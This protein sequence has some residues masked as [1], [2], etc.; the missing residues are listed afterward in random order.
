MTASVTTATPTLLLRKLGR[1]DYLPTWRAMQRFTDTRD[2]DSADEIWLT[3]HPPVYTLGLNA[4]RSHLLAPGAIPV[5]QV[6]R[7][8]QVTYH[9]PGQIMV[10]P[11]IDI[12]RSNIGV[13]ELV[14]ALENSVVKLLAI[15]GVTGVARADAPGVY[16]DEKKVAS[17]GLR[18]RRGASFH[19]MAVNVDV[20]T[21]PFAGINP[22]G[23]EDLEVTTLRELGIDD[24]AATLGMMLAS[25]LQ[26]T[27]GLAHYREVQQ[28][29]L[30]EQPSD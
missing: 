27:L 9:G 1:Q 10:Y 21:K 6:D 5:V 19:G 13:R 23:F 20:D 17:V 25:E 15:Y 4:D 16:V 28:T 18:I 8:G 11:L 2:A 24:D 26:S 3:E 12:R 22:C 14:C 7:G 29:T 30:P